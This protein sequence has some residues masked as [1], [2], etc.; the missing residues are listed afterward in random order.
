MIRNLKRKLYFLFA[1]S[2]MFVFTIVFFL[3]ASENIETMQNAELNFVN[4]QATNLTLLFEN[5]TN[6]VENLEIC[7]KKYDYI[8]R[9]FTEHDE[10]LYESTNI[11]DAAETIDLFLEKLKSIESVGTNEAH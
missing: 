3:L 8:F 4:R 2:I 7:E 5:S 6:Y 10:L 1:S 11:K 9:L